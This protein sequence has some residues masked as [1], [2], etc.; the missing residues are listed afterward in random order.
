MW[1]SRQPK[2]GTAFPGC[3]YKSAKYT[4]VPRFTFRTLCLPGKREQ[5]I[6]RRGIPDNAVA[7]NSGC[8]K[9]EFAASSSRLLVEHCGVRLLIDASAGRSDPKTWMQPR[10][11]SPSRR[12]AI[13]LP[14]SLS[15]FSPA[16]STA[17]SEKG[18][19]RSR[20]VQYSSKPICPNEM[21]RL[22]TTTQKAKQTTRGVGRAPGFGQ[23]LSPR[24]QIVNEVLVASGS[25]LKS[26]HQHEL[27]PNAIFLVPSITGRTWMAM[28]AN[29]SSSAVTGDVSHPGSRVMVTDPTLARPTSLGHV[30]SRCHLPVRVPTLNVP[31]RKKKVESSPERQRAPTPPIRPTVKPT[32]SHMSRH[33]T[34]RRTASEMPT[35]LPALR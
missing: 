15:A 12:A 34:D 26:P 4:N 6:T 35:P 16:S 20:Q 33:A 23:G 30:I 24:S 11:I 8:G 21:L 17:P 25:G 32:G 1:Q 27:I 13:I 31:G 19:D 18:S 10:I 28:R 3:S 2:L 9:G 5:S 7:P 29:E 22:G 14:T